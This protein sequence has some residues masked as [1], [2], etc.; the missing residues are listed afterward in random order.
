[1]EELL[2]ENVFLTSVTISPTVTDH[3]IS[4]TISP[5]RSDCSL[6]FCHH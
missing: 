5:T 1:M 6:H 4:V 2:K 3:C